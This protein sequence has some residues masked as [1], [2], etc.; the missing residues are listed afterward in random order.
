MRDQSRTTVEQN[1]ER[2]T[3]T[4]KSLTKM[5]RQT[6]ECTHVH[7]V[8]RLVCTFAPVRCCCRGRALLLAQ[9]E[10]RFYLAA[11][12]DDLFL[13][14]STFVY[15]GVSNEGT[16]VIL[17]GTGIGMW[18]GG[19]TFLFCSSSGSLSFFVCSGCAYF[20]RDCASDGS[21]LKR[22]GSCSSVQ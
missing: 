7:H 11:M 5:V 1:V 21:G 17:G 19:S 18:G 13:S 12:V 20:M 22:I 10:R 4:Q 9:G 14:T 15:D 6:C 3:P 16:E 8:F 2:S